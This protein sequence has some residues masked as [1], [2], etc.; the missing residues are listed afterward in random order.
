MTTLPAAIAY[1]RLRVCVIPVPHGEKVPR[2]P[3]WQKLR[4]TEEELPRYFNDQ[5]QNIGAL[6]GEPSGDLI[7]TDIDAP[8]ALALADWLPETGRTSGRAS[9]PE[10]HH[11]YRAPGFETVQF[12]DVDGTMLVELRSTGSQTLVPPSTHPSGEPIAWGREGT[13]A[14]IDAATLRAVVS[15][16]AAGALLARH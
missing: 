12:K 14:R 15:R 9:K 6:N 16:I 2:L 4:L 8:E 13:A 3:G 11:W 7:D 5:P 10:S 1:T